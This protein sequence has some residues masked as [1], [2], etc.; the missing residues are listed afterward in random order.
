MPAADAT[1]WRSSSLRNARGAII[2]VCNQNAMPVSERQ[3]ILNE[4]AE[5]QVLLTTAE[6]AAIEADNRRR[7]EAT[8]AKDL[9]ELVDRLDYVLR[10]GQQ[11]DATHRARR[12]IESAGLPRTA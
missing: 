7:A 4:V 3:K 1:P 11:T 12:M 5:L 6:D 9:S 2:A 8:R 10:E